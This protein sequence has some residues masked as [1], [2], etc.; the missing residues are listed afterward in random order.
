MSPKSIIIISLFTLMGCDD[1]IASS[2]TT[3]DEV[4]YTLGVSVSNA[5]GNPYFQT[6]YDVYQNFADTHPESKILLNDAEEDSQAQVQALQKM[7]EQGAQALIVNMVDTSEASTILQMARNANIPVVFWDRKPSDTELFGYK[8]A[9]FIGG[10]NTQAGVVQG[11]SVLSAWNTHPE[12]D[13]NSD[14]VIQYAVLQ[15][16][17]GVANTIA[18][19]KWSI[20]TLTSYPELGTPVEEIFNETAMYSSDEANKVTER[21]L[22]HPDS[23]N[24]EVILANNDSMAIGSIDAQRKYNFFIPTFGIDATPEA[25]KL[26]AEGELAG[27]VLNDAVTQAEV[28]IQAAINLINGLPANKNTDY[29]LSYQEIAVPYREV[30]NTNIN[31]VKS[32]V[33]T[34]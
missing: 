12:W 22:N 7:V 19:T 8:N 13:R 33:P 1:F 17:P 16:I 2:D 15:G 23:R 6:G 27:T 3:T 26:M 32:E 29:H 21:W 30:P 31:Q 25:E 20:S 9:V 10:D 18:R 4:H 34:F 5:I 24:I 14:G 28:S 11:L